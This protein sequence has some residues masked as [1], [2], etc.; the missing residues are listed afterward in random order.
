MG[1]QLPTMLIFSLSNVYSLR[2]IGDLLRNQYNKELVNRESML[3]VNKIIQI[4]GNIK[5]N[6]FMCNVNYDTS[7]SPN[8]LNGTEKRKKNPKN[9]QLP[10]VHQL[11]FWI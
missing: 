2:R 11:K 8:F 3:G 5:M 10:T 9:Q 7:D 1:K 6:K 4:S